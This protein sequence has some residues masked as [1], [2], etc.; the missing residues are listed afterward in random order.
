VIVI[1]VMSRLLRIDELARQLGVAEV[2]VRMWV[3]QR[4]I[5]YLRAP[6]G[7]VLLFE[8][9]AVLAA[10]RRESDF[11]TCQISVGEDAL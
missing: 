7:R 10:L 6:S 4:K 1:G 9:D 11:D 2:T 5:P 8:L 3:R